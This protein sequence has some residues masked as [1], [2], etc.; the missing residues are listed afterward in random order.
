MI[1]LVEILRYKNKNFEKVDDKVVEEKCLKIYLNGKEI[2]TLS[3]LPEKVEYLIYGFLFTNNFIEKLKD[4]KNLE[5]S[6]NICKIEIFKKV[7]NFYC[8]NFSKSKKIKSEFKISYDKILS[9]IRKFQNMS[10]IYKNTGGVHSCGLTNSEK[11]IIFAEDISRHNAFDK[12]VG[13][14]LFK[15]IN[16]ENSIIF[17]SGR[18]TSDIVIKGIKVQIPMIIS[19]SAPTYYSIEIADNYNITLIGFARGK[20]FNVYT[21]KW[22]VL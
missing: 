7:K 22:R 18:I 4:I 9:L 1:K 2:T 15:K 19:V 12:V 17:T 5:I 14:S 10:E 3:I 6:G 13:E 16:F 20:R 11:L 8:K 21:H